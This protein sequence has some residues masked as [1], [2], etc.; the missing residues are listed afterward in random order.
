[1]FASRIDTNR[2]RMRLNTQEDVD[3][4][5]PA[6]RA[7]QFPCCDS[8]YHRLSKRPKQEA[9]SKGAIVRTYVCSSSW[10]STP[11]WHLNKF[12]VEDPSK[13]KHRLFGD[14]I[15]APFKIVASELTG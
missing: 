14:N 3:E 12:V 15:A 10:N 13:A 11:K 2:S 8:L 1:M 9:N 7:N 4:G 6:S 5:M